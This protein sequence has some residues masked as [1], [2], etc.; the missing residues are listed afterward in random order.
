M[1]IKKIGVPRR[2]EFYEKIDGADCNKKGFIN[3]P[4]FLPI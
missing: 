4:L 2:S 3:D 1:N